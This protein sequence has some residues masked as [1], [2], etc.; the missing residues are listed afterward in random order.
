MRASIVVVGA[1][2]SGS[3]TPVDQLIGSIG[4]D[5]VIGIQFSS[6]ATI[7]IPAGEKQMAIP[8]PSLLLAMQVKDDTLMAL[9][10]LVRWHAATL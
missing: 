5:S 2:T 1:G 3:Q 4:V 9:V 7:K 8:S 10:K 6:D